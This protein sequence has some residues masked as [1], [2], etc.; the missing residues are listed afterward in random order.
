MVFVRE[1]DRD[2]PQVGDF[3]KST[4]GLGGGPGSKQARLPGS[5]MMPL[6]AI[7]CFIERHFFSSEE[8]IKN[9]QN[10]RTQWNSDC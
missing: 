7:F 10:Q 3:R 2:D 9:S 6:L 8:E 5:I 4:G 1:F